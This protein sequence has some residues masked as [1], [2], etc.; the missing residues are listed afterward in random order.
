MQGIVMA[1]SN[2][3]PGGFRFRVIWN[4]RYAAGFA[5]VSPLPVDL[6]SSPQREIGGPPPAIGPEGQGTPFFINLDRGIITDR[7]FAQ[8][9]SM[10]RCYGPATGKGSLLPEYKHPLAIEVRDEKGEAAST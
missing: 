8:W 2:D 10:V 7:G 3:P 6:K 5:E 9:I 4:G 1:A